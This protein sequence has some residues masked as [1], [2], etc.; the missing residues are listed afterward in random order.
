MSYRIA[1]WMGRSSKILEKNL[2]VLTAAQVSLSNVIPLPS[3]Q[4]DETGGLNVEGRGTRRDALHPP[5]MSP[6]ALGSSAP[7]RLG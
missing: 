4:L 5:V 2:G 7:Q 6:I 1:G 3:R